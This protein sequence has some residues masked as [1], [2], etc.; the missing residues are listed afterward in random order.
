MAKKLVIHLPSYQNIYFR[1]IF[2]QHSYFKCLTLYAP[3]SGLVYE[4]ENMMECNIDTTYDH[5]SNKRSSVQ[6]C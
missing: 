2:A 6:I 5:R 3:F 1:Y 4:A